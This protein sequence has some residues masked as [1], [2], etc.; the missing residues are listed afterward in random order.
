MPAAHTPMMQQY[1]RIKN[2]HPHILL[3]YRMGDFYEMFYDDAK[4]GAQL[5]D[6]TLTH[7]GSSAGEPIPMAGVPYHAVEGYLAKLMQLGESVAICEQIGDPQ[8][9]KG[10]VERKVVRIVTPGTVSDESLLPERVDNLLLAINAKKGR[11]G[12]AYLDISCGRLVV[13]ECSGDEALASELERLRAAEILYPERSLDLKEKL[14]DFNG[15]RQRPAWEFDYDNAERECC[16]LLQCKDLSGYGVAELRLALTAAGCLLQY[17]KLTQQTALTHI[18]KIQTEAR[19]DSL[20]MDAAT[21]QHLE[22]MLNNRGGR[23]H[24]VLKLLDKTA[25]A[26]GSRLLQRWLNRPLRCQQ[27]VMQR[28]SAITELLQH[29][30]Q[31]PLHDDLK[32]IA[33]IERILSRIALGSARPRDLAKLRDSI[34]LFPTLNSHLATLNNVK[35]KQLHEAITPFPEIVDELTRAIIDNPP[36]IIRDGGVIATGYDATLDE[37][38]ELSENASQYLLDLEQRERERTQLSTL[39]VGYNR[40][41]GYYIEIS[42]AQAEQAP[43]DYQRRQTLKN[44][45]RFIT[46]ELKT[47][48]DKVLSARSRALTREKQLYEQLI[49]ELQQHVAALQSAAQAIAECDV[50]TNLAERAQ[51]LNYSAPTFCEQH[52]I[53]IK[54]GRHCVIEATCQHNF[55]ANDCHLSTRKRMQ[56]ITGPNMGGKSTYM[57]QTALIVLL[58]YIGSYVPAAS[59]QLGPVDQLFTRIGAADDLSA[60]RSTFMVEMAETANILHNATRESVVLI[61][62]IGRGTSTFDGLSLAWATADCLARDIQAYTLFATHYFELTMLAE[63]I[64][65]IENVHVTAASERDDIVFLYQVQPGPASQSYGIQ[66]AK[67][68]GIPQAVLASAKQK[69]LQLEATRPQAQT[70]PIQAAT[71]SVIEEA[72]H[73]INPDDLSPKQALQ[74][75]YRLKE[76]TEHDI[77]TA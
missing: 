59:A 14:A 37:L 47:F 54:A 74:L 3:F 22:I 38:R 6:L 31:T 44:A 15:S 24:T 10:P 77:T 17:V 11:Y 76:L 56:M 45:E 25:T 58:A 51:Q 19:Q 42:K 63:Q 23:D 71:P 7:R 40:V 34:A 21:R 1:W 43:T 16:Q 65:T 12:L 52:D 29:D 18:S 68:A 27:T 46:P 48:E 20:L 36:V 75:I 67:L 50:L 70:T 49:S 41:H 30:T 55:I 61:D 32:S 13:S 64:D 69:L 72:L 26:M 39:K 66:V 28:Q 5:L 8:A 9:S 33:D 73:D 2:E 4:R 62:E 60:G 35:L 57:R 53:S